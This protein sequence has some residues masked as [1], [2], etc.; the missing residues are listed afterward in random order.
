MDQDRLQRLRREYGTATLDVA[1]VRPDPIEQFEVWM[2]EALIAEVD[3][4]NAMVLSTATDDGRPSGRTVLLK[5]LD[6]R[7]FVFFTNYDS[8]KAIELEG[9]PVASLCFLWLPLHRQVRVEGG[10]ERLTDSES[11]AYFDTRPRD[12]RIGAHA[13]PQ[14][15]VIPG[16][17]WLEERFAD[18]AGRYAGADPPRPPFWGGYR[19]RP[20]MVELWQGR[21]NRLHD[22]VRYRR[23]GTGWSVERLAP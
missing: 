4:P 5:G 8:R 3:E 20:E 23:E 18:A 13:S 14:S 11:D 17:A 15:R 16:R 21:Q 22:R 19:V 1:D 7:G 10:V 2:A 12:A 9:N 6:Q